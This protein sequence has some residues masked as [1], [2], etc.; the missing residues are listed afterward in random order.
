MRQEVEPVRYKPNQDG[1]RH[2]WSPVILEPEE[3]ERLCEEYIQRCAD[4]G[5]RATKPG[6]ALYI[7]I[8]TDTMDRWLKAEDERHKQYTAAIK[9][10]FDCMSD[11]LQQGKDA[12]SIF[13]L[14]QPC[15]GGY[16]DRDGG[17]LPDHIKVTVSFGGDK[18]PKR[19]NSTK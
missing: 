11:E 4:T 14:K 5:R 15:Y 7:G 8:S 1:K 12:V 16:S 17:N 19:G 13:L 10:A 9:K 3:V 18:P 6:L 2:A